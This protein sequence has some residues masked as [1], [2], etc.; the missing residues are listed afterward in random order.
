MAELNL[1]GVSDPRSWKRACSEDIGTAPC[2]DPQRS[3]VGRQQLTDNQLRAFGIKT[4]A[5]SFHTIKRETSLD[6]GV[7]ELGSVG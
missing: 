7:E 6:D 2:A 3:I 5:N 4:L 1:E